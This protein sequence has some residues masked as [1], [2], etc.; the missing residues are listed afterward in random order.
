ML[1]ADPLFGDLIYDLK[2]GKIDAVFI[3]SE[4]AADSSKS[5]RELDYVKITESHDYGFAIAFKKGNKLKKSINKV[6]DVLKEDN[7]LG[8][9][10]IKW[11]H[12]FPSEK[13]I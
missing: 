7:W 1:K 9:L 11:M 10:K 8:Q 3:D 2:V 13:A 5:Y 4:Q 6:L 12:I